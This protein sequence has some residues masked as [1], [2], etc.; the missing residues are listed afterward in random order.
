MIKELLNDRLEWLKEKGYW[1]LVV[2]VISA[3]FFIA[4][5]LSTA[6]MAFFLQPSSYKAEASP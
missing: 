3:T 2:S 5:L 6:L 1:V 4:A